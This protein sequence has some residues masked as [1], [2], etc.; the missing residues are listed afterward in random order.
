MDGVWP[1]QVEGTL[2]PPE[3]VWCIRKG[4]GE[5]KK[6]RKKKKKKRRARTTGV[7][8]GG[9][10]PGVDAQVGPGEVEGSHRMGGMHAATQPVRAENVHQQVGERE[11]DGRGLLHARQTPE[12]PLP[13]VLLHGHPAL[14]REVGERVH[15]RVLALVRA[16]PAR[17]AQREG[18]R[19]DVVFGC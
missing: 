4:E 7:E 17:E 5:K 14:H 1:N 10:D 8:Y 16:G 19:T 6:E 15:A 3:V 13:V 18:E 11:R 2:S 9:P 12:R